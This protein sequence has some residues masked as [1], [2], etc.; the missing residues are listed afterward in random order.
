MF[1][2]NYKVAILG[3]LEAD[4]KGIANMIFKCFLNPLDNFQ[5]DY[6]GGEYDDKKV[7]GGLE[8]G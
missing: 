7:Y 5:K 3:M 1:T 4:H 8:T 2:T 6:F